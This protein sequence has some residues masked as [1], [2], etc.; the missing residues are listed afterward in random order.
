[1]YN[2][3]NNFGVNDMKNKDRKNIKKAQDKANSATQAFI[4]PESFKND[5]QGSYTG[6]PKNANEVP[7]QD[8]DDL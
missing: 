4:S 5:P 2:E 7:T 6:R 3:H 1:M 8:A